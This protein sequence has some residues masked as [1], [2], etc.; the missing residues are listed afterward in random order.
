MRTVSMSVVALSL[1]SF[2]TLTDGQPLRTYVSSTS[3]CDGK[4]FNTL[5]DGQPLRTPTLRRRK[6]SLARFQ[7]HHRW[8]THADSVDVG[9]RFIIN[10]FQYPHRWA[11]PSDVCLVD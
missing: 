8:A 4:R 9:G 2:N 7:Y 11:T 5:T 10:K 1:T 6:P 3:D